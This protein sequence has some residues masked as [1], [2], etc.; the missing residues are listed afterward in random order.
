VT[1]SRGPRRRGR[2]AVGLSLR[3]EDALVEVVP[4]L[5]TITAQSPLRFGLATG[6]VVGDLVVSGEAPERGVM[7]ETPNLVA[8]LQAGRP[9]GTIVIGRTTRRLLAGVFEY[10]FCFP[11]EREVSESRNII[12]ENSKILWFTPT[13]L[14][15]QNL[16]RRFALGIDV[17]SNY[18]V[19][20]LLSG[21][22]LQR[23]W[24]HKSYVP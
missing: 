17:Y 18:F 6:L 3:S 22:L 13:C 11:I 19:L 8:C 10:R 15:F 14:A 24:N 1:P 7:G 12:V 9:P 5:T 21:L 16:L 23:A 2:S 20:M 4:K